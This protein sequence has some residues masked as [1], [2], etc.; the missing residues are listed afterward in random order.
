MM[1]EPDEICEVCGRPLH[2]DPPEFGYVKIHAGC[3]WQEEPPEYD[4]K[5][6]HLGNEA[7][8]GK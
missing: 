7:P 5:Q 1:V 4:W 6:E 3:Q 2:Y 8:G